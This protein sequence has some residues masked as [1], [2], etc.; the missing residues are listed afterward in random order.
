ML[1]KQE[2]QA[3]AR[4]VFEPLCERFPNFYVTLIVLV[5]APLAFGAFLIA[6]LMPQTHAFAP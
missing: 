5:V 2:W 3:V 4:R 6:F 1:A